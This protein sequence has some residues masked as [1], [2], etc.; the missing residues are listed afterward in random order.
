V[1]KRNT[2]TLAKT[3]TIKT[4]DSK[5]TRAL[6]GQ[7]FIA[8]LGSDFSG[9]IE[10]D[11]YSGQ[12][13]RD[14]AASGHQYMALSVQSSSITVSDVKI[15]HIEDNTATVTANF[16]VTVI[17][18]GG[19]SRTDSTAATLIWEKNDDQ[20]WKLNSAELRGSP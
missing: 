6:K 17:S 11:S 2:R 5:S 1:V 16:R 15:T 13:S 19:S 8:L 7:D 10:I 9:S 12:I 20:I 3:L 14:D 18:K 4:G